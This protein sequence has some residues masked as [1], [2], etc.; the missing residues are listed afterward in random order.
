MM[1]RGPRRQQQDIPEASGA[2]GRERTVLRR[3]VSGG[4][5]MD[6]P[7]ASGIPG[8]L[9]SGQTAQYALHSVG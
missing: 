9:K 7:M 8:T 6:P 2:A 1:N 3:N 4:G 5:N